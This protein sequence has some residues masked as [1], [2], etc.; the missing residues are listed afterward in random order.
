M[1]G[2]AGALLC[3][4]AGTAMG[5]FL[6]D[7]RQARLR[8][9][10]CEADVLAGMRLLLA[11]ERLGMGDLLV[12]SMGF[13]PQNADAARV[14]ERLAK[15]AEALGMN[16]LSGVGEAYQK[17]CKQVKVPWEQPQERDALSALFIQ[18]GSGTAAMREQAVATCLRR[19]KPIAEQAQH[20]AET[21]G[22]L[23]MQLGMLLGL[24]AG[25]ALW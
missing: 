10:Q 9:L 7:A 16:P 21:G 5:I 4:A 24:M 6:R 8:F 20:K 12:E 1:L 19:L 11:Q 18:L 25:I 15:T 13:A 2:A 3:M 17:A 14:R 23:C 22:R